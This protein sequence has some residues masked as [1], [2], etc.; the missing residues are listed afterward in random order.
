M[1]VYTISKMQTPRYLVIKQFIENKIN[2]GL[3][4]PGSRVPSEAELTLEFAV[5]RMTARRALSELDNDGLISRS[6]GK[7]SFV[8]SKSE[9]FTKITLPKVDNDFLA[10]SD[11][12]FRILALDT[13]MSDFETMRDMRVNEEEEIAK[14]VFLFFNQKTPIKLLYVYAKLSVHSAFLKQKFSKITPEGYLDWSLPPDLVNKNIQAV[15]LGD[16]EK[17]YLIDYISSEQASLLVKERRLLKNEITSVCYSY[18]LDP[19]LT[20]GDW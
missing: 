6:A 16:K 12:Y 1:F 19:N 20:F 7:G 2:S 13:V 8:S 10:S 14:G 3:W 5:S 4:K 11:A 9:G 15:M 17:S 18:Y